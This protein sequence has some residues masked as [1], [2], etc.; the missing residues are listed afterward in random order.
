MVKTI[1]W[2]SKVA[3]TIMKRQNEITRLKVVMILT[4]HHQ[5]QIF[6]VTLFSIQLNMAVVDYLTREGQGHISIFLE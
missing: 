4:D 6:Y 2:W 3:R 1:G 5:D